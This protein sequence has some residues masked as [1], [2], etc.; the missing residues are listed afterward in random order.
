[1]TKPRQVAA[2]PHR[3]SGEW[4]RRRSERRRQRNRSATGI[5]NSI[6]YDLCQVE[7]VQ[8]I[9][10]DSS[11]MLSSARSVVWLLMY[12]WHNLVLLLD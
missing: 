10:I 5:V 1:M 2:S 7:K 4:R 9:W 3:F 6:M 11:V 8:E 12:E